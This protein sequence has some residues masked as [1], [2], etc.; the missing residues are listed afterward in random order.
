[1]D[2]T[3]ALLILLEIIAQFIIIGSFGGCDSA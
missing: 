3:V 2:L 1:M